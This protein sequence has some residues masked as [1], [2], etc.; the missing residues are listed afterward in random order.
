MAMPTNCPICYHLLKNF[1]LKWEKKN[2]QTEL[3]REN[4]TNQKTIFGYTKNK[5]M[6]E[7]LVSC[8][9][10][11][12]LLKFFCDFNQFFNKKEFHMKAPFV[13]QASEVLDEHYKLPIIPSLEN[14][15]TPKQ[16]IFHLAYMLYFDQLRL[17]TIFEHQNTIIT[18]NSVKEA[19]DC[20]E[21]WHYWQLHNNILSPSDSNE[22]ETPDQF[23]YHFWY[24]PNFSLS[25][26]I[27]TEEDLNKDTEEDMGESANLKNY[28]NCH[29]L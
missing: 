4:D 21:N 25:D 10:Y 18:R 22:I 16:F 14:K 2:Q 6:R 20:I 23:G 1:G 17:C 29:I 26:Y 28:Y 3:E 9:S 13:S 7:R 24:P 8:D 15:Y 11:K 5:Y 12:K 19:M 27:K